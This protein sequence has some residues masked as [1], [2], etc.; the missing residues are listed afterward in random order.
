LN[1]TTAPPTAA[2]VVAAAQLIKRYEN[3]RVAFAA[4]YTYVIKT[5][6]EE[7]LLSMLC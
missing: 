2:Q 3:V 6:G 4:G 5:N 1:G 7:H